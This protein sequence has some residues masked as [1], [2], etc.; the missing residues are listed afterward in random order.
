MTDLLFSPLGAPNEDASIGILRETGYWDS[1]TAWADLGAQE[2]NFSTVGNQQASPVAALVE[3]LVNSIDA[4]LLRRCLEA[5]LDPEGAAAPQGI[6]EAAEQLLRIPHGNLAHCT[7]KELTD[8]AGHVGLVATGAKNLPNLTVFDDGEGQEPTGFPATLLSIGRSNKLRIP[9]VQGK[10]NM[11]GTGVL[12]FCGRHNLELIVSRRA[13]TLKAHDPSWGYTVVRREDPQGGRRSSVYRYLAPDGAVLL[14]PGN[15]IPLDRLDVKSGSSLPVLAAGTI[16]KLFGYSLPPALRTNILFDLRN[17]IAALMTSPALPVRLYE[18]RAGFQGHSLEANVEG[19]ATRLERDTRDNLE[20]PP[21]AHTFS[22]GDQ[23]L[24]ANVYAFK[25]RTDGEGTSSASQKFRT[26][27]GVIFTINGQAHGHY[28][29]VFFKRKA[30]DMAFL[31]EDLLVIVDA[32]AIDGR[33]REDLFMNS[34]DRIRSG[35]LARAIE[36]ELEQ[37]LNTHPLLRDLRA[38]R[39]A[40]LIQT[41][42]ADDQQLAEVLDNIIKR[43]PSLSALFITGTRLSDPYRTKNATDD[44]IIFLGREFPTYYRICKGENVGD[45]Q[46]GRRFRVQFETDAV[47]EYFSRD[48]DPGTFTVNADGYPSLGLPTIN[49]LNGIVTW[50]FVL[51]EGVLAN[52]TITIYVEITDPSRVEPFKASFSRRVRAPDADRGGS[53]L[54][55]RKP[56]TVHG[57]GDRQLPSGLALPDIYAVR[58]EQ[59]SEHGFDRES[60]LKVMRDRETTAFFVNVDNVYL[61]SELRQRPESRSLAEAKFKYGLVLFGLAMLRADDEQDEVKGASGDRPERD[62]D[63]DIQRFSRALAPIL[64]PM[65]DGLSDLADDFGRTDEAEIADTG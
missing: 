4:V 42:L 23:L 39:R 35:E 18:R 22:V 43:S 37:L 38:R 29:K 5:G 11:G 40:E 17:H 64:L 48:S 65:I 62:C 19:L 55:K 47:N 26:S 8:L 16:I 9:F 3:K 1:P 7:A 32:T 31:A 36:R 33:T 27:E 34:R 24:K 14:S 44:R 61:A 46:V 49:A 20:F 10:F 51:P 13:E 25:R 50:N 21:T 57:F 54:G 30:V 6:R 2:N 12:Q 41:R 56:P 45:A 58:R 60:A 53:E 52:E 15:P 28:E 59:W 63:A